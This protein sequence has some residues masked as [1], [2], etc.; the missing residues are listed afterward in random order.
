MRTV[1]DVVE[2]ECGG[3][4]PELLKIDVQG[5]ELWV[6]KG[7][8]ESLQGIK[9]VLLEINVLDI[10]TGVPLFHEVVS[11]LRERGWVAYDICGLI[12]RPLDQALWQADMIFVPLESP[13]R[14]DKR[15]ASEESLAVIQ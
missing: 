13:L 12:R 10:Y 3:R 6:L 5:Y 9:V 1:D 8:A 4:P 2:K 7:A 11:W 15:W 14:S